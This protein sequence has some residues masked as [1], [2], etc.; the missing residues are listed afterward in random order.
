[1]ASAAAFCG[2]G[3]NHRNK[4]SS[5]ASM[6]HNIAFAEGVEWC[7]GWD[8]NPHTRCRIR[9]FKSLASADFATRAQSYY[10]LLRL[11][12]PSRVGSEGVGLARVMPLT[13]YALY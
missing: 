3:A 10:L 11:D 9:D 7:P 6:P 2:G 8:L 1:M 4:A 13:E 5:A 12:L